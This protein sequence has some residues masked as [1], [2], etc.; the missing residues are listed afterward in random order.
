MIKPKFKLKPRTKK[1]LS[2]T[3]SILMK[4]YNKQFEKG[5]FT[6]G[7]GKSIN[8]EL[9]DKDN[10]TV[11]TDRK[12]IRKF[13]KENPYVDLMLESV[14][15]HL[16]RMTNEVKRI[17]YEY[18]I[19]QK[20]ITNEAVKYELDKVFNKDRLA[21]NQKESFVQY[22]QRFITETESR[23]RL[24]KG[25]P[26]SERTITKYKAMLNTWLGTGFKK[27][28]DRERV[29]NGIQADF[30]KTVMFEHINKKFYDFFVEWFYK[31]GYLINTVGRAV[32]ELKKIMRE[33]FKEGVHN[34]N[35]FEDFKI[36]KEKVFK[37]YLNNDEI[38]LIYN[39]NL[40]GKMEIHRDV[41][42]L[43]CC[44]AQR[45]S[46]FKRINKTHISFTRKKNKVIKLQTLKTGAWV[47]IPFSSKLE[48]ILEKYDYKLPKI[49]EYQLNYDIKEICKLAG[50]NEDINYSENR[51][52]KKVDL[53]VKKYQLITSHTA[54][55]SAA[56]NMYL[57]GIPPIDIM[58]LTGHTTEESFLNY[59]CVTKEQ[60]A[61]RLA[62][63]KYFK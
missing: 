48:T 49:Q 35:A 9:W 5:R 50:I 20:K 14:T 21:E 52:G 12:I 34:N 22:L 56:T 17:F 32:K 44:I 26:Y 43:G 16:Q 7:T 38:D 2:E 55:R 33:A 4:V 47:F 24:Y 62:E 1:S 53:C 61:D 59:I 60:V 31:R 54:R 46:D 15:K 51:G 37:T 63:H 58:K 40:T 45:I 23:K 39:L 29:G 27:I 18:D 3:T 25:K 57:A 8:P 30:G 41:F 28:T 13:K 11:I 6:Y 42:I 10:D 19:H 36:L